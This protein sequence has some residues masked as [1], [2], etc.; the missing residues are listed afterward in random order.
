MKVKLQKNIQINA[1]K[2][3]MAYIYPKV[4]LIDSF[5]HVYEISFNYLRARNFFCCISVF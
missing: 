5:I 2:T 1:K 3:F 4:I